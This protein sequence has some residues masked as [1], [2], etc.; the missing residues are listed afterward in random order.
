MSHSR[1][2][3]LCWVAVCVAV[4]A[5]GRGRAP[6]NPEYAAAAERAQ[7]GLVAPLKDDTSEEIVSW[8]DGK[9]VTD[10]ATE[11]TKRERAIDGYLNDTG[12]IQRRAV[13][14]VQDDSRSRSES[15]ESDTARHRSHLEA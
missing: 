8:V 15:S 3:G 6:E 1:N 7:A 13:R 5:C 9:V 12:R 2:R 10:W 14:A 11:M 4:C